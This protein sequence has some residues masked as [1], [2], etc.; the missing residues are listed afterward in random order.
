MVGVVT[1]LDQKNVHTVKC[2]RPAIPTKPETP[3]PRPPTSALVET[4]LSLIG[5]EFD[6]DSAIRVGIS[7][8][9]PDAKHAHSGS[10]ITTNQV[11]S[12]HIDGAPITEVLG[13]AVSNH[14]PKLSEVAVISD[15]SNTGSPANDTHTAS[16]SEVSGVCSS[17][18]CPSTVDGLADSKFVTSPIDSVN[19]VTYPA[20]SSCPTL[21][22]SISQHLPQSDEGES[23]G[24][25]EHHSLEPNEHTSTDHQATAGPIC[26]NLFPPSTPVSSSTVCTTSL[27]LS[28]VQ[29]VP[30]SSNVSDIRV[31]LNSNTSPVQ[32]GF[33]SN[34]FSPTD[35]QSVGEGRVAD[36]T[37]GMGDRSDITTNESAES[38]ISK[39]S[40]TAT[41]G[42]TTPSI[43]TFVAQN[44]DH[45]AAT[46]TNVVQVGVTPTTSLP[47]DAQHNSLNSVR[48][49]QVQPV[50]VPATGDS[51]E[52]V[53][54]ISDLPPINSGI[55]ET[56]GSSSVPFLPV[57]EPVSATF[58][59]TSN[60]PTSACFAP[61]LSTTVLSNTVAMSADSATIM[62]STQQKKQPQM[63]VTAL[64]SVSS[65]I[66]ATDAGGNIIFTNTPATVI[67]PPVTTQSVTTA[68]PLPP[69]DGNAAAPHLSSSS[70]ANGRLTLPAPTTPLPPFFPFTL[71][72]ISPNGD[73]P[74]VQFS[75]PGLPVVILQVLP[76]P[77]AK[78]GEHYT[79]NVP[80]QLIL[81]GIASALANGGT[82]NGGPIVLSITPSGGIPPM[83][84]GGG[85]TVVTSPSTI[86]STQP[87]FPEQG[88]SNHAI[89]PVVST[90]SCA[91]DSSASTVHSA[92]AA[93][94]LPYTHPSVL[95]STTATTNTNV[96]LPGIVL[97][98]FLTPSTATNIAGSKR[99]RAIA[100]KPSQ[101]FTV[102][103]G[104]STVGHGRNSLGGSNRSAP[105]RQPNAAP[106][107]SGSVTNTPSATAS[108]AAVVSVTCPLTYSSSLASSKNS[109]SK[110]I[111][112]MPVNASTSSPCR[113][114]R[115]RRRAAVNSSNGTLNVAQVALTTSHTCP[116]TATGVVHQI[117]G[118]ISTEA[119]AASRN[120]TN[121]PN[122]VPTVFASQPLV[123]SNAPG[124]IVT[125]PMMPNGALPPTFFFGGALP[126]VPP[127]PTTNGATPYLFPQAVPLPNGCP[128]FP[129]S[130]YN[131]ANCPTSLPSNT[132]C[133]LLVRPLPANNST[134][135]FPTGS[136]TVMT[137]VD[138]TTGMVT[139]YP[140]PCIPMAV[141][142]SASGLSSNDQT[143]IGLSIVYSQS[144]QNT[145]GLLVPSASQANSLVYP[146][147]GQPLIQTQMTHV[148]ATLASLPSSAGSV[149]YGDGPHLE[150]YGG[151]FLPNSSIPQPNGL[152][153]STHSTP[154][155]PSSIS[156]SFIP[157]NQFFATTSD[158]NS[159]PTLSIMSSSTSFSIPAARSE[160]NPIIVPSVQENLDSEN[161]NSSLAKDDL[162][163]LAW[164]L[165]QMDDDT[166]ITTTGCTQESATSFA[167][168][169]TE[170]GSGMLDA[171]LQT[172][173]QEKQPDYQ[174]PSCD[175]TIQETGVEGES[176]EIVLLD[177]Q[178]SVEF[179]SVAAPGTITSESESLTT[180]ESTGNADIDAL[181]AAAAM[182]GAASGVGDAQSSVAVVVPSSS[183]PSA[184]NLQATTQSSIYQTDNGVTV[185]TK[186]PSR[187][188]SGA[189][190]CAIC[191]PT[192]MLSTLAVTTTNPV[193]TTRVNPVECTHLDSKDHNDLLTSDLFDQFENPDCHG[194]FNDGQ[195]VAIPGF[196]ENEEPPSLVAVLGCNA[197]D[198]A[199]LE[200]VLDPDSHGL[201]GSGPVSDSFLNSLVGHAPG[202]GLD[203][204]T[205]SDANLF[206]DDFPVCTS[207]SPNHLENKIVEHND[208]DHTQLHNALSLELEYD[209]L[210]KNSHQI[211]GNPETDIP[212]PS[213]HQVRSLL[214]N[215]APS[216]LPYRFDTRISVVSSDKKDFD[217]FFSPPH[218]GRST[219]NCHYASEIED[220]FLGVDFSDTIGEYTTAEQFDEALM[221]LG[222]QPNSPKQ[223]PPK[224][225]A[226][227]EPSVNLFVP[228]LGSSELL[229]S[230]DD[231]VQNA[232]IPESSR[233]ESTGELTPHSPT[234]I[235]GVE[236]PSPNS[237]ITEITPDTVVVDAAEDSSIS[238]PTDL[239]SPRESTLSNEKINAE[240]VDDSGSVPHKDLSPVLVESLEKQLS[241]E[242]PLSTNKVTKAAVQPTIEHA[243]NAGDQSPPRKSIQSA[244]SALEIERAES[245]PFVV[246]ESSVGQISPRNSGPLLSELHSTGELDEEVTLAMTLDHTKQDLPTSPS[247]ILRSN[248]KV[249]DSIIHDSPTLAVHSLRN[250]DLLRNR[251][252]S[253][254]VAG[255]NLASPTITSSPKKTTVRVVRP[256]RRLISAPITLDKLPKSPPHSLNIVEKRVSSPDPVDDSCAPS[257]PTQSP[258]NDG[259]VVSSVIVSSSGSLSECPSADLNNHQLSVDIPM[260]SNTNTSSILGVLASS[261]ALVEAAVELGSDSD[262]SPVKSSIEGLASLDRM[263]KTCQRRSQ[264]MTDATENKSNSSLLS[265]AGTLSSTSR[266]SDPFP[267]TSSKFTESQPILSTV[268]DYSCAG[269]PEPVQFRR[270]SPDSQIKTL[271]SIV[272]S[273]HQAVSVESIEQ[274][275]SRRRSRRRNRALVGEHENTRAF[276]S[277]DSLPSP[278]SEEPPA[279][280]SAPITGGATVPS[281][282]PQSTQIP[283]VTH[284]FI[285]G[286]SLTSLSE[287]PLSFGLSE[288][289]FPAL[290]SIPCP[291]TECNFNEHLPRLSFTMDG[292]LFPE[293]ISSSPEIIVNELTS[294][295]P[296]A[297]IPSETASTV[298]VSESA[299]HS[300][301]QSIHG[302]NYSNSDLPKKYV[303]KKRHRRRKARST[304]K[305]HPENSH[306]AVSIDR[307]NRDGFNLTHSLSPVRIAPI[308]LTTSIDDAPFARFANASDLPSFA[309]MRSAQQ[310]V[311]NVTKPHTP[312]WV[313]SPG[314]AVLFSGHTKNDTD[315]EN[316]SFRSTQSLTSEVSTR[317]SEMSSLGPVSIVENLISQDTGKSN[318]L[319]SDTTPSTN[320]ASFTASPPTTVHSLLSAPPFPNLMSHSP[321]DGLLHTPSPS[322][323]YSFSPSRSDHNSSNVSLTL[324][325]PTNTVTS[326]GTQSASS[327]TCSGWPPA[328]FG[329]VTQANQPNPLSL[330]YVPSTRVAGITFGSFAGAAAFRAT[331]F[332]ALAA[333]ADKNCASSSS[334]T[335]WTTKPTFS[336]L[337]KAASEQQSKTAFMRGAEN[338]PSHPVSS[339]PSWYDA[340]PSQSNSSNH[341]S[342]RLF[343]ECNSNGAS[344]RT[345][346]SNFTSNRPSPSESPSVIAPASTAHS[347]PAPDV[348][349]HDSESFESAIAKNR[350]SSP[351][352][353]VSETTPNREMVVPAASPVK[354]EQKSDSAPTRRP[355]NKNIRRRRRRLKSIKKPKPPPTQLTEIAPSGVHSTPSQSSPPTSPLPLISMPL[356]LVQRLDQMATEFSI[357]PYTTNSIRSCSPISPLPTIS[358]D[359]VDVDACKM[360]AVISKSDIYIPTVVEAKPPTNKVT[361]EVVGNSDDLL[362][363]TG[364][365]TYDII[366]ITGSC[367]SPSQREQSHT[368]V[369]SLP[370]SVASNTRSDGAVV[371]GSTPLLSVR[372]RNGVCFPS[373]PVS[374]RLSHNEETIV[375]LS[376]AEDERPEEHVTIH[377][378]GTSDHSESDTAPSEAGGSPVVNSPLSSHSISETS[379][380][381]VASKSDEGNKPLQF[382]NI[383]TQSEHD[384]FPGTKD[385]SSSPSSK[386]LCPP[387]RLR[388]N[389]KLA[390]AVSAKKSTKKN[391]PKLKMRLQPSKRGLVSVPVISSST[392][393]SLSIRLTD[394]V[395]VE[396]PTSS[397]ETR[398]LH[399]KRK[400]SK[401]NRRFSMTK[402]SKIIGEPGT[403]SKATGSIHQ[404]SNLQQDLPSSSTPGVARLISPEAASN[405]S[406]LR[407]NSLTFT[408]RFTSSV[409]SRKIFST[410]K[411]ERRSSYAQLSRPWRAG[412]RGSPR[413]RGASKHQSN[414]VPKF[415]DYSFLQTSGP[416]RIRTNSAGIVPCVQ[417]GTGRRGRPPIRGL[418]ANRRGRPRS[419]VSRIVDQCSVGGQQNNEAK[420]KD[421]RSI[422]LVIRLG[423]SLPPSESESQNNVPDKSPMLV[424]RTP[425]EKSLNKHHPTAVNVDTPAHPTLDSGSSFGE[426]EPSSVGLRELTMND[427]FSALGLAV[428]AEA[429]TYMDPNQVQIHRILNRAVAVR[430]GIANCFLPSPHDEDDEDGDGLITNGELM[431]PTYGL[432][433]SGRSFCH[434]SISQNSAYPLITP[435]QVGCTSASLLNDEQKA[436]VKKQSKKQFRTTKRKRDL[437]QDLVS[438]PIGSVE[439][440]S[441]ERVHVK[442]HE[443]ERNFPVRKSPPLPLVG[444]PNFINA[445]ASDIPESHMDSSREMTFNQAGRIHTSTTTLHQSV[446]PNF[447]TNKPH[448]PPTSSIPPEVIDSPPNK[449][450]IHD[451]VRGKS[452]VDRPG[453]VIYHHSESSGVGAT[454]QFARAVE[455]RLH[456]STD[457]T[458]PLNS[459]RITG[460]PPASHVSLFANNEQLVPHGQSSTVQH[461][462]SRPSSYSVS[463]DTSFETRENLE[464]S[465]WNLPQ[466]VIA[467]ASLSLASSACNTVTST[468]MAPGGSGGCEGRS[469]SSTS[470]IVS[471]PAL[472]S[473]GS[474]APPSHPD[475]ACGSLTGFNE[476][477]SAPVTPPPPSITGAAVTV[478]ESNYTI[479]SVQEMPSN[480]LTERNSLPSAPSASRSNT[481][482]PNEYR[483]SYDS[484]HRSPVHDPN[485]PGTQCQSSSSQTRYPTC[486]ELS[487]H[488]SLRPDPT[489]G[490]GYP[491]AS[492]LKGAQTTF[493]K[494]MPPR[495]LAAEAP[496]NSVP[497]GDSVGEEVSCGSVKQQQQQALAAATAYAAAA[498]YA[499]LDPMMAAHQQVKAYYDQW[500]SSLFGS[501]AAANP[502]SNSSGEFP[503]PMASQNQRHLM[504][505]DWANA[506]LI[507]PS[508]NT[509]SSGGFDERLFPA[510][511]QFSEKYTEFSKQWSWGNQKPAHLTESTTGGNFAMGGFPRPNPSLFGQLH[512]DQQLPDSCLDL[513]NPGNFGLPPDRQYPIPASYM[514]QTQAHLSDCYRRFNPNEAYGRVGAG[515]LHEP[516]VNG[517]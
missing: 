249:R 180:T 146:V 51:G 276:G 497:G 93:H 19:P 132:S 457:H 13:S 421:Q 473:T 360:T 300:P 444:L 316:E 374:P 323:N 294:P 490:T 308:N 498:A 29:S 76:L 188:F 471:V 187:T 194:G 324:V 454:D 273:S 191:S 267:C 125:G 318:E 117:A 284:A 183:F 436:G 353:S 337:A 334:T 54:A 116:I 163:S 63:M 148:P 115:S 496:L 511:E 422:R 105:K 362:E 50:T 361:E 503:A 271:S 257:L 414:T 143:P 371:T 155:I 169:A 149:S 234:A 275:K 478:P 215:T 97:S 301:A 3:K 22:P 289:L 356:C 379:A 484:Y 201:G 189:V 237:A 299:L 153:A 218:K 151:A 369:E 95:S 278:V 171:L 346:A 347:S 280:V 295:Q 134:T 428:A 322:I 258:R 482:S 79:I 261:S 17:R 491:G 111:S 139:H 488:S 209:A 328:P 113:S 167:D 238:A 403:W 443:F 193:S 181:L 417:R 64:Q 290:S 15:H 450:H 423:R 216:A 438:E 80:T 224:S 135:L 381:L 307:G 351:D 20:H 127:G 34:S 260:E 242:A 152:T 287:R 415:G 298:P 74:A 43:P 266:A 305:A 391:R 452:T 129:T 12:A 430:A 136:P 366:D 67:P 460:T 359:P 161:N 178:N 33:S 90:S 190:T 56:D 470:S 461:E 380:F 61:L 466:R 87:T 72:P 357:S 272:S 81:N 198:A 259:A 137:A 350:A 426:H 312:P 70:T 510:S 437:N 304:T 341:Q 177:P 162:I 62:T 98:P 247:R 68:T 319:S 500:A 339:T 333:R 66:P 462:R 441:S 228:E 313:H 253:A 244:D 55:A 52:K 145:V 86:N 203:E 150:S 73:F 431:N 25:L 30:C 424:Q 459:T 283:V 311:Q 10:I 89:A 205:D 121:A 297:G 367:Q 37:S 411:Q 434:S 494:S 18:A 506:P 277:T 221:L 104:Q 24:G 365:A 49:V 212:I 200:S 71:M 516:R 82:V 112:I 451:E 376:D 288:D 385:N 186:A 31:V 110:K 220:D 147:S 229:V 109:L 252:R 418:H 32:N 35:A 131:P 394:R 468:S 467:S 119:T 60:Y 368:V 195:P 27:L 465:G 42:G 317:H 447:S 499:S 404:V 126:G 480:P 99:M 416:K 310:P 40:T 442:A 507:D 255:L 213:S 352:G 243:S 230:K 217:H 233:P 303:V 124:P 179:S 315:L 448:I 429:E 159:N 11:D 174:F 513:D 268:Y 154:M 363:A 412:F 399:R 387:I 409:F 495:G 342:L 144:N 166:G 514:E 505:S 170:D 364:P 262:I 28:E 377:Q 475:Y 458:C 9:D 156:G 120:L 16:L 355:V 196:D 226:L 251:T 502:A 320:A 265:S 384:T 292:P 164:R 286:V 420:D 211:E 197:E 46:I 435:T 69:P 375:I 338:S 36:T 219:K 182:V 389:L 479:P 370:L 250:S 175:G 140:A 508:K 309:A 419:A 246:A 274:T 214:R 173:S 343:Q 83:G 108:N 47:L 160:P 410:A 94:F 118:V 48:S 463:G 383:R 331:S 41:E 184:P 348:S 493:D 123:M 206:D 270:D 8:G 464:S 512:P 5:R 39:P 75:L 202:L 91:T 401:K 285:G 77:G 254:S 192:T 44:N 476:V 158:C 256:R 373:A 207:P 23:S 263:L 84:V 330:L 445:H 101:K 425:S 358:L 241:S 114:S 232:E 408:P 176:D 14:V 122:S 472:P 21:T 92:T 208:D 517:W 439:P 400:V 293:S 157:Q 210:A 65:A 396:N 446:E 235:V 477:D 279:P 107:G 340:K 432:H 133:S 38:A 372:N 489:S 222:P 335:F 225:D 433:L 204:N 504:K 4:P 395:E 1:E 354:D 100:P 486:I 407:T 199:D 487:S 2:T 231:G 349:A 456:S 236:E 248:S 453:G 474:P 440:A 269:T 223:T 413:K 326:F 168:A 455:D 509:S 405:N 106:V 128:P 327:S 501:L 103:M 6:S 78:M 392:P 469:S 7:G 281:A 240:V 382:T 165:T 53:S 306:P 386:Q 102:V 329:N 26:D 227:P 172:Y 314:G 321:L 393:T 388:L 325:K 332:S 142:Y 57:S 245:P 85:S 296:P 264:Q 397:T 291:A 345:S 483:N 344:E 88:N 45:S 402:S 141:P 130:V 481:V 485:V 390:T 302:S 96:R 59:E 282:S 185:S 449:R 239:I 427:D 58:S 406:L 398:A 138:P 492:C 515:P 336:D 378:T